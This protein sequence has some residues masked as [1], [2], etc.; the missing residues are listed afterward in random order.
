LHHGRLSIT[1][2]LSK[3]ESTGP[4]SNRRIRITGAESWPLDDQC[5]YVSRTGPIRLRRI[6]ARLEPS[7]TR[8]RAAGHLA[9]ASPGC[10]VGCRSHLDPVFHV[11]AVGVEPTTRVL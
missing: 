7:P 9:P 10:W 5:L 11:A 3:S 1:T 6:G 2:K 4:D 8:L